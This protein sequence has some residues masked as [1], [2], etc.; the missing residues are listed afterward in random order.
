M[1]NFLTLNGIKSTKYDLF[2]Q[3]IINSLS[4]TTINWTRL[5][6]NYKGPHAQDLRTFMHENIQFFC[7]LHIQVIILCK[8]KIHSFFFCK[9]QVIIKI[10]NL[11]LFLFLSFLTFFS[12]KCHTCLKIYK[13]FMNEKFHYDKLVRLD[14]FILML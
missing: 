11:V 13:K 3:N 12:K 6:Q 14:L 1:A 10:K 2:L 5:Q 7:H 9:C 8:K 4:V